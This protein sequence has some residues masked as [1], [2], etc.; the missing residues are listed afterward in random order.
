MNRVR[1]KLAVRPLDPADSRQMLALL[2]PTLFDVPYSRSMDNLS[3]LEQCFQPTPPTVHEN[4]WLQHHVLGAWD[5]EVLVGFIDMGVGYDR[6]TLHLSG[7][8]PLGLLRFL[9]LPND[10]ILASRTA[11]TLLQAAEQFWQEAGVRRIRAFSM[12]TGYPAFQSGAGV[13]PSTWEDHF[14]WL[15][16]A[17]YR[18][19]ERY[20]CRCYPLQRLAVEILP[21][22]RFSFWP[23][24]DGDE[25]IYRVLEDDT[26]V[27]IARVSTGSMLAP[28][29]ANPI[30]YLSQLEVAAPWR[31]RGIGRWLLRRAINDAFLMG[32]KQLI[33]HVNHSAHAAISLFNQTG[34]EELSYRGYTLEKRL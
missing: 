8:R 20:Y 6:S 9:A 22:C 26:R 7:E 33:L 1:D 15:S 19:V 21:E 23:H 3:I 16:E 25:I 11:K 10:Y 34:L 17:G 27:A 30:A 2:Y 13:L 28:E 5:G 29:D 18:L 32:C 4:R 24:Q 31:Q 12:S 14:R